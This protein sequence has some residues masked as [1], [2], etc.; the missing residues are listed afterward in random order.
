MSGGAVVGGLFAANKLPA[1]FA[2]KTQAQ[3][4]KVLAAVPP[5]S[6]LAIDPTGATESLTMP[7]DRAVWVYLAGN[8]QYKKIK[9]MIIVF[10]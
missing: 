1:V 10:R 4:E 7:Q 2:V 6:L 5:T 8:G 9:G 3:L